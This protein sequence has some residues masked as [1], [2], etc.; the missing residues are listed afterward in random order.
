MSDNSWPE[1]TKTK[2][3]LRNDIRDDVRDDISADIR[4]DI[5]NDIKNDIN[6]AFTIITHDRAIISMFRIAELV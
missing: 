2:C 5:M 6:Y 3:H 1:T 4:D